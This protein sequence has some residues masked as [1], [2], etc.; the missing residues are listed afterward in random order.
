MANDLTAG[1]PEYRSKRMQVNLRTDLLTLAT[2]NFEE[3]SLLTEGDT[4]N[5]PMVST[6]KVRNYVKWV[7][8]KTQDRTISNEKLEINQTKEITSYI[9]S[10]DKIQNNYDLVNTLVDDDTYQLQNEIDGRYLREVKHANLSC[11]DWD[12]WGTAW[13]WILLAVTNVIKTF[14][15]AK[16][17]MKT[18]KVESNRPRNCFITPDVASVLEQ[19]LADTGF[20]IADKTLK[21]GYR[22]DFMGLRIFESNNIAHLNAVTYTGVIVAADTFTVWGVVFTAAAV[23]AA[24]GEFDVWATADDS[25]ANLVSAINWTGTPSATTYIELSEADRDTMNSIGAEAILD[26]TGSVMDVYTSWYVAVSEVLSN[27]TLAPTSAICE[28]ARQG[29]T[30]VVMQKDP[31]YIK[32]EPSNKIWSNYITWDLY[33]IKT[34]TE[35]ANRMLALKILS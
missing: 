21:A 15:K 23:P 3:R 16:A 11:D 24:A 30:D 31:W 27:A 4:V 6:A 9:D 10:V 34:F 32:R 7:D 17:I 18:W 20:N 29:A 33:G 14:S 19:K 26:T 2:A 13:N 5:R 12:I 25:Y 35:G 22:W 28:I 8:T 1:N